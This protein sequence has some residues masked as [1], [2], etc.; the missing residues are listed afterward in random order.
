M[1]FWPTLESKTI[2]NKSDFS[3]LPY[4]TVN[5][6]IGTNTKITKHIDLLHTEVNDSI[7]YSKCN[8]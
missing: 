6:L 1:D 8:I 2:L 3:F 7:F 5:P 4:S